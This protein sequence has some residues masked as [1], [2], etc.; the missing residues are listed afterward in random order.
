MSSNTDDLLNQMRAEARSEGGGGSRVL[1]NPEP[2]DFVMGV[3]SGVVEREAPFGTTHMVRLVQV[4]TNEGKADPEEERFIDC[5]PMVLQVEMLPADLRPS[6]RAA[7]NRRN[8]EPELGSWVYAEFR[9]ERTPKGGGKPYKSFAVKLREGDADTLSLAKRAEAGEF[10]ASSPEA[11]PGPAGRKAD[12][13]DD[14]D[15]PFG[16]HRD[17]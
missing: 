3:W 9:G 10:T 1:M 5:T 14:S 4:T 8:P 17:Y 6:G 15:I 13:G 2:G 12:A 16:E 7:D 11:N